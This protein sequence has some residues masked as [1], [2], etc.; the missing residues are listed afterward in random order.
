MGRKPAENADRI[1]GSFE[2]SQVELG[3]DGVQPFIT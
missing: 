3:P 1:Y 2:R